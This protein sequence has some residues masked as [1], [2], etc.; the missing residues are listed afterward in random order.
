MRKM[1]VVIGVLSLLALIC[2]AFFGI[3]GRVPDEWEW[4]SIV[5]T[6]LAIAMAVPSLLQMI[7]GRACIETEFKVATRGNTRSILVFLKNPPV[8]NRVLKL[9]GVRR[10][11]VQSFTAE[12][13]IS[14]QGSKT[15]IDPIRVARLFSDEDTLEEGSNRIVLPPT[16]SVAACIG[17]GT[18]DDSI[19]RAVIL[20]DRIRDSLL[21]SKGIY[22]LNI[23]MF[24]DG[25]PK[26]ISRQ[27]VVGSTADDLV[28]VKPPR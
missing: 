3:F 12:Y 22:H 21:L 9:L 14:E 4:I 1:L 28:W 5:F 10:E 15:I 25:E 24:L 23:M 17:I 8:K 19:K 26:E 27:L 13:R 16:Y 7:W 18:W 2:L 6:G 11:T 20:E